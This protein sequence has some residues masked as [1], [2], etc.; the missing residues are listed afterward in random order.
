MFHVFFTVLGVGVD[1]MFVIVAS[2]DNLPE[3]T[4]SEKTIAERIGQTL[5]EAVGCVVVYVCSGI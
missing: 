1:D 4:H 5:K 3:R 2:W